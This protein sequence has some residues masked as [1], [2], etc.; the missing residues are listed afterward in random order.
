MKI[1][2]MMTVYTKDAS[3]LT[4]VPH[5]TSDLAFIWRREAEQTFRRTRP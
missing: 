5:A 4:K 1:A 3:M 2:E